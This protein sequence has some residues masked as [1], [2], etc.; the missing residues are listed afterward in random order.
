MTHI[1]K[2]KGKVM[3]CSSCWLSSVC[4]PHAYCYLVVW[5]PCDGNFW[6]SCTK[7]PA[8]PEWLWQQRRVKFDLLPPKLHWTPP[9]HHSCEVSLSTKKWQRFLKAWNR[10]RTGRGLEKGTFESEPSFS[11]AVSWAWFTPGSGLILVKT[12]SAH[13]TRSTV[14][15]L[16]RSLQQ[17]IIC[18]ELSFKTSLC[19]N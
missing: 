9:P 14:W 4:Y 16:P 19:N 6:Y 5:Q 3:I 18:L 7:S 1:T 10:K 12:S 11:I 13:A 8:W 17:A 2:H 15:L